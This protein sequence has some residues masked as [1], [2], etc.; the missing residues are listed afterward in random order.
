[1]CLWVMESTQSIRIFFHFS[2]TFQFSVSGNSFT[3][4]K[5]RTTIRNYYKD[6]NLYAKWQKNQITLSLRKQFLRIGWITS[7]SLLQRTSPLPNVVT[8]SNFA[9]A[10]DLTDFPTIEMSTETLTSDEEP[11]FSSSEEHSTP[12]H[13]NEVT[14]VGVFVLFRLKYIIL[15]GLEWLWNILICFQRTALHS[16]E[17]S[18]TPMSPSEIFERVLES[19]ETAVGIL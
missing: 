5:S 2:L 19:V 1:M 12:L 15:N 14:A 4:K 16:A 17:A 6:L 18:T 9:Q 7:T 10:T 8:E 13:D 11:S 3:K